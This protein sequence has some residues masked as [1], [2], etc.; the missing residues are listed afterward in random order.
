MQNRIKTIII[1][2]ISLVL[3]TFSTLSL[4]EENNTNQT[5]QTENIIDAN[6]IVA[7]T[8]DTNLSISEQLKKTQEQISESEGKLSYVEGELS[9]TLVKIAELSDKIEAANIDI[10]NCNERIE[11]LEVSIK[12]KNAELRKIEN[13]YDENS[14]LLEER[15]V[16][17]YEKGE[18][19][20]LD[21][22]LDSNNLIDFLSNYYI[23]RQLVQYDT[24]LLDNIDKEKKIV[25]ESRQ[26]LLRQQNE[27]TEL[28]DR[29][30]RQ[31]VIMTNNKVLLEGYQNSLN[32]DEKSLIDK[33]EQYKQNERT[34]E[35]LIK[36]A[37]TMEYNGDAP[38][39]GGTMIWPVL[40]SGCIITSGFGNRLHPIQGVYKNHAGID[41]AASGIY[42][43]T[44]VAAAD[45]VISLAQY[46]GGYG[47]C[48]MINHG[49]GV[50]TLYGH[51]SQILEETVVGKEVKAGDPI[52]LVGSTGNS[53]GPHLHFEVRI[54]GTPVNPIP[55]LSNE[56]SENEGQTQNIVEE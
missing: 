20:Y 23:I 34:L 6:S 17:M 40:K 55:F 15:L 45:G 10:S 24:E 33:I 54:N 7:N 29:Q 35:S 56:M 1:T 48:V 53:T 37:A 9:N 44:V 11:K 43:A 51:G 27:I 5:N 39:T 50:S 4:A 3:C 16:V 19:T 42:G 26:E 47:N 41:I 14:K 32:S 52:M 21:I 30:K 49:N 38:Y 2:V 31:N 25:D 36:Q 28:K 12:E 22:L 46:N 18:T 8:V 13:E